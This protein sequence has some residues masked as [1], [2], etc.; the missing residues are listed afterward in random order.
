MHRWLNCVPRQQPEKPEIESAYWG[1]KLETRFS[2]S[3]NYWFVDRNT[4]GADGSRELIKPVTR[5]FISF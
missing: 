4:A 1:L 2:D 3:G 5:S